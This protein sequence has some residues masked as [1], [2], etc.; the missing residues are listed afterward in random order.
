MPAVYGGGEPLVR[1]TLSNTLK[2][3]QNYNMR[4]YILD[5]VVIHTY[6]VHKI[7]CTHDVLSVQNVLYNVYA[8]KTQYFGSCFLS[9][10]Y[11]IRD[12]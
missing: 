11:E 7:H 3:R 4:Y 12:G 9:V 5:I 8:Q 1:E 10:F 2:Y 6:N